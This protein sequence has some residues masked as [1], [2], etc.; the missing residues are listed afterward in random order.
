MKTPSAL[1]YEGI[2]NF[3]LAHDQE[4][5][6]L[7]YSSRRTKSKRETEI[8][9]GFAMDSTAVMM[10]RA[11]LEG[12]LPK[13]TLPAATYACKEENLLL[14]DYKFLRVLSNYLHKPVG[15]VHNTQLEGQD[16]ADNNKE[17]IAI[18][19]DKLIPKKFSFIETAVRKYTSVG[20]PYF[21]KGQRIIEI[22]L[23][24]WHDIMVITYPRVD[25]FRSGQISELACHEFL[26]NEGAELFYS[27]AERLQTDAFGK[28]REVNE[29]GNK[30]V[31]VSKAMSSFPAQQMLKRFRLESS[32]FMRNSDSATKIIASEM[33]NGLLETGRVRH[34]LAGNFL[35]K[36]IIPF[37][38]PFIVHIKQNSYS[39]FL[40]RGMETWTDELLLE[41]QKQGS[42]PFEDL[43]ILAT[44]IKQMERN[45]STVPFRL[46]L[47]EIDKIIP[48][49]FNI[50]EYT[51]SRSFVMSNAQTDRDAQE[52]GEILVSRDY[53]TNDLNLPHGYGTPSGSALTSVTNNIFGFITFC[54]EAEAITKIP[55][56]KIATEYENFREDFRTKINGDDRITVY[57]KKYRA[58]ILDYYAKPKIIFGYPHEMELPPLYNGGNPLWSNGTLRIVPAIKSLLI[59]TINPEYTFGMGI[60]GIKDWPEIGPHAKKTR[61]L[62]N[63]KAE[64]IYDVLDEAFSKYTGKRYLEWVPLSGEALSLFNEERGKYEQDK[65]GSLF[66]I[67]ASESRLEYVP[68]LLEKLAKDP[69]FEKYFIFIENWMADSLLNGRVPDLSRMKK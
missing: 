40:D 17:L 42:I 39:C 44:D 56:E 26:L 50:Q 47:N 19:C 4:E 22:L 52:F 31:D 15:Y 25:S 64:Q 8:L 9:P 33:M 37:T 66:S 68:G 32:E 3:F 65:A 55:K 2:K 54:L 18:V 24:A 34:P 69:R 58:A 1:M 49:P 5:N 45:T 28:I 59:K 48:K 13:G 61:Y 51:H 41:G 27:L 60:K 7:K 43:C 30:L 63:P 29:A 53:Y 67:Y 23:R 46:V 35:L 10:I 12:N 36:G 14:P 11:F 21:E 38:K 62:D 57:H 16:L 20:A 6:F